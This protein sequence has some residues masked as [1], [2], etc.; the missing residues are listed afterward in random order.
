MNIPFHITG[1]ATLKIKETDRLSALCDELRKLSFL[2]ECENDSELSWTG[3]R[4]PVTAEE[5][6][7]DTYKDHR[8]AM[9]FAPV[10]FF[11]P[12]LIIKDAGVVTKS[13]PEFWDDMRKAGFTIQDVS[14][15]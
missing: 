13:Y 8:M 7:I 2:I 9:A 1:L 14:Q 10:A 3:Q 15:D 5:V 11:L 6:A 4:V 12:G